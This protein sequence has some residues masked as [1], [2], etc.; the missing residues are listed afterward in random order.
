MYGDINR[1]FYIGLYIL[2]TKIY[3]YRISVY[4]GEHT[5][6][7]MSVIMDAIALEQEL[8][9]KL[10]E[11]S[12]KLDKLLPTIHT[13]AIKQMSLSRFAKEYGIPPSTALQLIH[14]NDFPA[15]KISGRWYVDIASYLE[16]RTQ[17]HKRAYRFAD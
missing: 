2:S 17:E 4:Y 10:E 12:T 3:R 14:R 13:P 11:L 7:F 16:W 5:G 6:G 9:R 1:D 15:Y 8:M